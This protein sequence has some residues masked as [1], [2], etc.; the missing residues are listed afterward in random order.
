MPAA[1]ATTRRRSV[2]CCGSLVAALLAGV[3]LRIRNRHYRR[4]LD[5]EE[6]DIDADG[7]PDIFQ[8]DDPR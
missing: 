4:H 3:V 1:T 7:V 2:S 8:Q 5:H 6:L